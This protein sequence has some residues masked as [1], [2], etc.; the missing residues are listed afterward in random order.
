MTLDA[1]VQAIVAKGFTERQ[2]RFLVLVMRHAC[3]CA[4]RQ[5]AT[6]AGIVFGEK[7]RA[8]FAKL[9]AS[10]TPRRSTRRRAA[11]GCST[12]TAASCMTP[13]A[14][15]TA[16]SVD[17]RPSPA[18]SS[19]ACSSMSSSQTPTSCGWRAPRRRSPRTILGHSSVGV[20]EVHYAHLLKDDLVAASQ[21]V[22]IPVAPRGEGKVV[23]MQRRRTSAAP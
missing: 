11:A 16:G 4:M 21:Q 15:R 20:T 12:S 19:V 8:F 9:G 23:R 22:R 5:D 10:A 3:V 13:S 14:S 7:T 1:Q 2:A 18:P 17:R 6:F